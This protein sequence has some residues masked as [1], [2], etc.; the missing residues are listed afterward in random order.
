MAP[1]Q[2]LWGKWS[3]SLHQPQFSTG[4]YCINSERMKRKDDHARIQVLKDRG[5]TTMHFTWHA[6]NSPNSLPP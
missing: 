1:S 6:N 4:T 3:S 2:Q 5:N